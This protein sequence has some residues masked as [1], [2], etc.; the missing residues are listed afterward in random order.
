MSERI[1]VETDSQ[2]A[3]CAFI[4]CRERA[5]GS[6]D[7]HDESNAVLVQ[8]DWDFPGLA[9]AFG[10]SPCTGC[11][12]GCEGSTDGTV[13]CADRRV[14]DMIADARAHLDACAADGTRVEDPGYFA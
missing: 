1:A 11:A 9:S 6:I 7:M 4:V 2:Y 5:E 13:E 12:R 10:W 3:P 14:D 8:T